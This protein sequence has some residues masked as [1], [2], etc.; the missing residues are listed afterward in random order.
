MNS[1]LIKPEF[2][3]NDDKGTMRLSAVVDR[4]SHL[5][6]RDSLTLGEFL[7]ELSVYGHMMVCLIFSVPFL[8]PVPLPGLST[9]FGLVIGIAA[10]QILLGQDP[11]VPKRWRAREISTVLVARALDILRAILIRT[12]KIIKPR[13]KFFARHPGFV[14]INGAIILALAVLLALPMPPGFNFP[15]ALAIMALCIGSIERDG[16][17]IIVG[18][19]SAVLN[20]ILFGAFFVMGLE[21]IKTLLGYIQ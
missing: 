2:N 7:H 20:L 10:S 6:K 8:L 13:L 17:L 15:P 5:C 19:V 9:I 11:W 4:L 12:E 1:E 14:R 3:P 16:M 18:Y 21:G